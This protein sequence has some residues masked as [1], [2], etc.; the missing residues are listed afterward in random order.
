MASSRLASAPAGCSS[1][2]RA[3][4]DRRSAAKLS[5]APT[6][7][8]KATL[9]PLSC[10][11]T[12]EARRAAFSAALAPITSRA[13]ATIA[14][15]RV[16]GRGGSEAQCHPEDDDALHVHSASHLWLGG[17]DR[18]TLRTR[19]RKL[20]PCTL[21]RRRGFHG[22][23]ATALCLSREHCYLSCGCV[24]CRGGGH[25]PSLITHCGGQQ[26]RNFYLH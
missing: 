22:D 20:V 10:T 1:R 15:L 17:R 14:A 13:R 26:A 2:L 7:K 21:Q 6:A 23:T 8:A 11:A 12:S 3:R 19:R 16:G 4:S 5:T 25:L 24:H 9:P 18:N